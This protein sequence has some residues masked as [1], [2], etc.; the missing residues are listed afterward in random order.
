MGKV[1]GRHFTFF[2][3]ATL[4]VPICVDGPLP[5]VVMSQAQ[6]CEDAGRGRGPREI[7]ILAK[8]G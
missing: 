3:L 8:H 1:A 4:I 6:L 2:F 7:M 5:V